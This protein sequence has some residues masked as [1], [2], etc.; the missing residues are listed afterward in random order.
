M[1]YVIGDVH[2][3]LNELR[4]LVDAI[5]TDAEKTE[6]AMP[7]SQNFLIQVAQRRS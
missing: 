5:H 7:P 4:L 3:M 2:G 1:T 6:P